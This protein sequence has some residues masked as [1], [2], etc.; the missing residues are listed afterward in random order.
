MA[1]IKSPK[2]I[3]SKQNLIDILYS[4]GT[5]LL[6]TLK[7]R[8][9]RY[10]KAA[11]YIESIM[12]T[13][14]PQQHPVIGLNSAVV[15]LSDIS[16]TEEVAQEYALSLNSDTASRLNDCISYCQKY[17]EATMQ[18]TESHDVSELPESMLPR[19]LLEIDDIRSCFAIFDCVAIH[20]DTMLFRGTIFSVMGG[21]ATWEAIFN[22]GDKEL[23]FKRVP[24]PAQRTLTQAQY[25]ALK[26]KDPNTTYFITES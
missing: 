18:G 25:D 8:F 12:E 11:Q 26:T 5:S 17:I 19:L 3:P 1:S 24:H 13:P 23:L 20:K 6:D 4:Y 16:W 2:P 15:G 7:E 14:M 9:T 22:Y 21:T 10:D